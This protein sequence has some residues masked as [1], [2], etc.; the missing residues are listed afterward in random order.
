[1]NE[2]V[3]FILG[4]PGSSI[5]YLGCLIKLLQDPT[6]FYRLDKTNGYGKYDSIFGSHAMKDLN[7]DAKDSE[8]HILSAIEKIQH[9]QTLSDYPIER[10]ILPSH[11]AEKSTIELILEKIPQAKIIFVTSAD[12]DRPQILTNLLVKF[13]INALLSPESF[14][15][16]SSLH[17][18]SSFKKNLSIL[19]RE[20]F[21]SINRPNH[22]Y[23]LELY[24]FIG[25][26][27]KNRFI[28]HSQVPVDNSRVYEIKFSEISSD[29]IVNKLEEITGI[30][31]ESEVVEFSNYFK[32]NQPNF[33]TIQRLIEDV[34]TSSWADIIYNHAI[35]NFYQ[36]NTVELRQQ[37]WQE[38]LKIY[39]NK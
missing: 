18:M 6:L 24:D 11:L 20:K 5:H 39:S 2:S 1:M 7:I 34:K 22:P 30:T 8:L 36:C 23:L 32:T 13:Y 25:Q 38:C 21:T 3:Y 19:N 26:F 27:V 15:G 31:A 29:T 37:L 9:I 16:F 33:A 12:S 14:V 28:L 35:P 10:K 17:L 4:Q